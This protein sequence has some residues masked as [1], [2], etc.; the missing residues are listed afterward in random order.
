MNCL[1]DGAFNGIT[2]ASLSAYGSRD[3]FKSNGDSFV[4]EVEV[5]C[6]THLIV[7]QQQDLSANGAYNNGTLHTNGYM[8]NK[9]TLDLENMG[10]AYGISGLYLQQGNEVTTLGSPSSPSEKL[11][12]LTLASHS[13]CPVTT[14]IFQRGMKPFLSSSQTSPVANGLSR[15]GSQEMLM[16]AAESSGLSQSTSPTLSPNS[17][18]GKEQVERL[19]AAENGMKMSLDVKQS[20]YGVTADFVDQVLITPSVG[21]RAICCGL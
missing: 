14:A 6:D 4:D 21:W 2:G 3:I 9:P 7:Q 8:F 15:F 20:Y 10:M 5:K 18:D 16:A 12:G 17:S 11:N 13:Y 19:M 1:Q